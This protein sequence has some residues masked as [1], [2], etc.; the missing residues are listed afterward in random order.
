MLGLLLPAAAHAQR[1][2]A[3]LPIVVGADLALLNGS[4]QYVVV[5][6]GQ[7]LVADDVDDRFDVYVYAVAP[8]TWRRLPLPELIGAPDVERNSAI[9]LLSLSDD[10][11]YLAYLTRRRGE[12]GSAAPPVLARYDLAT[13]TRVVIR[14]AA[15]DF[16]TA[17]VMSRDGSTFAWLGDRNAVIVATVGQRPLTVGEACPP[18]SEG[19]CLR[20]LC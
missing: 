5:N 14:D 20:G 11:R 16:F 1:L 10:G 7:R 9:E 4:G 12:F 15:H 6:T 13:G 2:V 19:A 8:G 17:A 3:A 18:S